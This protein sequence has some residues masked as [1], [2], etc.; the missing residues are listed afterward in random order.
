M[1]S[2]KNLCKTMT[3]LIKNIVNEIDSSREQMFRILESVAVLE[4]N[5][6]AKKFNLEK[7]K[8]SQKVQ[9]IRRPSDNSTN[10]NTNNSSRNKRLGSSL[11]STSSNGN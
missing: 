5:R 6:D 9:E 4:I 7:F 2:L 10:F 3:D 8:H 11:S 1:T